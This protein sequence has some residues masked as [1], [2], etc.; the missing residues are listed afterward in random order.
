M[1][2]KTILKENILIVFIVLFTMATSKLLIG[3]VDFNFIDYIIKSLLVFIFFILMVYSLNSKYT[4]ISY[5][6]EE[7]IKRNLYKVLSITCFILTLIAALRVITLCVVEFL[8]VNIVKSIIDK[9]KILSTY[10]YVSELSII[11]YIFNLYIN[12]KDIPINKTVKKIGIGLIINFLAVFVISAVVNM[13]STI[14]FYIRNIIII[15][16]YIILILYIKKQKD[17]LKTKERSLLTSYLII[18]VLLLSYISFNYNSKT[19]ESSFIIELLFINSQY[20]MIKILLLENLI[21]PQKKININ[22]KGLLEWQEDIIKNLPDAIMLRTGDTIIYCNDMFKEILK[23]NDKDH[24][25]GKDIKDI[26]TEKDI[27]HMKSVENI[28]NEKK[29]VV[30][31]PYTYILNNNK[32]EIE[33]SAI[34]VRKGKVNTYLFIAR[35]LSV[36]REYDEMRIK[37]QKKEEEERIKNIFISNISHELK[38]PLNVIYSAVQMQKNNIDNESVENNEKYVRLIKQNCMRLL[39]LVNNILDMSKIE[40]GYFC[41]DITTIDIVKQVEDITDS[42]VDYV[43]SK[44]LQII[45]DTTEEE[46]YAFCDEDSI[47]RIVLN[48]ISNAIK[49]NRENGE[50]IVKTDKDDEFAYISVKN[51]GKGIEQENISRIFDRFERLDTSLSRNTEGSGIG[52]N[53]IKSIVELNNGEIT[54]ESILN[55]Y[56][57]ITIKLPLN[58]E[59]NYYSTLNFKNNQ[60]KNNLIERIDVELSDI[61]N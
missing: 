56:T 20:T 6:K 45:F 58:K 9:I 19:L 15:S 12:G 57:L 41:V 55:E 54:V 16:L 22:M 34:V 1:N 13:D 51:T 36:R 53:L 23:I 35:D 11:F 27:K 48:L 46:I 7:T 14:K 3:K 47:E 28:L 32:I 42:I 61:Y 26:F 17:K 24:L 52:L 50:I 25:I 60:I 43:K 10:Y 5:T 44:G 38:T 31:I 8:G 21:N 49:F 18:K 59:G 40:S 37:L 39:R 33:E 29:Y 30:S 4:D 2:F